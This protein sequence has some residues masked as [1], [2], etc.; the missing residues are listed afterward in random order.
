[1]KLSITL[2]T[3]ITYVIMFSMVATSCSGNDKKAETQTVSQ[4][5]ASKVQNDEPIEQKKISKVLEPDE[6]QVDPE[7]IYE[8]MEVTS[9]ICKQSNPEMVDFWVKNFKYPDSIIVDGRI[10]T[11][12]IIEKDG[13]VSD[14]IIVKGLHPELDK[15]SKRV[16]KLIPKFVPGKLN[17]VVVRSKYSMPVRCM[18]TE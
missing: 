16:L 1:M 15:E 6:K 7:K 9:A 11:D 12:L 10:L 17:G 8:Q 2:K 18:V 4:E 14:V 3:T 13:R 5:I